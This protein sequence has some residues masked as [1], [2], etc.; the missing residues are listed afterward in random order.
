[1]KKSKTLHFIY[2]SV[3]VLLAVAVGILGFF[4]GKKIKEDKN[5][6]K[7]HYEE[8]C[9]AYA[10]ENFHYSKG[11]IVFIGDSITE[12]F[13][14]D[15]Y[16]A[17]LDLAT[18]NRGIAGDTTGGVLNRLQVSLFDIKP[19]KIVLLIGENDVNGRVEKSKILENYQAIL[20]EIS[21]KLPDAQV[22][23]MSMVPPNLTLETYTEID[24]EKTIT[25]MMELNPQI[26]NMVN[27]IPNMTYIDLFSLFADENNMLIE[28]YSDDGIHLNA[29]A[30]EVWANVI[31]PYL[32]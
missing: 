15:D 4:L 21:T 27:S 17:E 30:F 13:P 31:K 24:V 10:L 1:M 26:E 9:A 22:Y 23:C 2:V 16:F 32:Q 19:S 5:E 14:L 18:Y 29:A 28:K 20:N 6:N 11:Q 25:T 3:I 7:K 8:K 12:L